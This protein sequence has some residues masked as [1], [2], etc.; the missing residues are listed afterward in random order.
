MSSWSA[1]LERVFASQ[2]KRSALDQRRNESPS[3]NESSIP[4]APIRCALDP[5]RATRRACAIASPAFWRNRRQR[6]NARAD[7]THRR[8]TFRAR[9]DRA[10]PL[11]VRHKRLSVA[12]RVGARSV[13][14]GSDRVGRDARAARA[15]PVPGR[16]DPIRARALPRHRDDRPRRA[17]RARCRSSSA[18]PGSMRETA[19]RSSSS[20]CL[21]R[22]LGEEA[23][24][25]D[26]LAE[27]IAR[28]LDAG[29]VQRQVVRHAASCAR[30]S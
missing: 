21:L 15:R 8:P 9:G 30:A 2:S 1:K 13:Q 26:R 16:A 6:R 10:G 14:A 25:L 4:S 12:H 17:A 19:T 5:A 11:Y 27:R 22:E 28:G 3:R 18:S 20:S 24:M 23:P 7:P 29:H